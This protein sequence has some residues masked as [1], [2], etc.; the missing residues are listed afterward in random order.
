MKNILSIIAI[1]TLV[2]IVF[3]F[4]TNTQTPQDA[5][6][7]RID[8]QTGEDIDNF[9]LGAGPEGGATENTAFGAISAGSMSSYKQT[10]NVEKNYSKAN[11]VI[12]NQ[13][14]NVAGITT[15]LESGKSYTFTVSGSAGQYSILPMLSE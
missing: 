6:N 4:L 15:T 12:E 9:W 5:V 10:E 8:N 2:F 14:H 7:I 3:R 11:F 13:R 1:V